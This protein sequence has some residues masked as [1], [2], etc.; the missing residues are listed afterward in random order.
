MELENILTPERKKLLKV[1]AIT[2]FVVVGLFEGVFFY[3]K[4]AIRPEAYEQ[5]VLEAIK[6][7]TGQD[8]KINGEVKFKIMPTPALVISCPLI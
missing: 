3:V 7:Q 4:S 6:K 8:I 2:L 1:I 5:Q